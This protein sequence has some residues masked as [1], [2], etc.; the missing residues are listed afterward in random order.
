MLQKNE[1]CHWEETAALRIQR[2]QR[3]YV[4]GYS[5]VSVPVPLIRGARFRVG[6]YRGHPIDTTVWDNG[7]AGVLHVTNQRICFTGQLRAV[8]IPYNKVIS[9]GGFDDGFIV[10]TANEKKP[11]VFAVANPEL[12]THLIG[13]AYSSSIDAPV[14]TKPRKTILPVV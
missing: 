6:G 4:G 7:G 2:T 5:S 3:E 13:L 11:G 1:I 12:T 8:A 10:Q 14:Q 9:I